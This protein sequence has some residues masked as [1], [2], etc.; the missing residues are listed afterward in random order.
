MTTPSRKV[1]LRS[2]TS[3]P[4]LLVY[5]N[6]NNGSFEIE[7]FSDLGVT[8][9]VEVCT[10]TGASVGIWKL[11]A[12]ALDQHTLHAESLSPGHYLVFWRHENT[13]MTTKIIVN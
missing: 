10:M 12:T 9:V 5:P 7:L 2:E 6:P 11:S 3:A 8:G 13:V 1:N 4:T